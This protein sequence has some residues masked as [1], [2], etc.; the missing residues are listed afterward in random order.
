MS[1]TILDHVAV[2]TR[3]L[4]DGWDLFSGVLG[5]SWAYGGNDSGFWWGPLEFRGGP[6]VELLTPTGGPDGAFLERY[7]AARGPGPHHLNFYVTDINQTLAAVRAAGIEPVGVNLASSTWKEAFLHPR[8]A[9][10]I[11]VQVAQQSGPPPEL[12]P[13]A[14]LPDPGPPSELAVI[15]HRVDDLEG[16]IRLFTE[17][18]GGS[19]VTRRV[20]DGVPTAELSWQSGTCLR[21]M[22]AIPDPSE[23]TSRTSGG[24]AYLNFTRRGSA[25]RPDEISRAGE[26]SKRLGL[27]LELGT[28]RIA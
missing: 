16:A 11:V 1:T 2:A 4:T 20:A 23:H 25:F 6:K 13:P 28:E 27:S 22:E 24:L 9:Y 7:L 10:G 12:A 19:V 17:V 21:L 14:E 18:L 8:D 15:G 5:G 3:T 26:L